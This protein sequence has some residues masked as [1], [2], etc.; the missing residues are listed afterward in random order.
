MKN[1]IEYNIDVTKSI[2]VDY[3]RI[4]GTLNELSNNLIEKTENFSIDFSLNKD[5]GYL[6]T[7]CFFKDDMNLYKITARIYDG[8]LNDYTTIIPKELMVSAITEV[9]KL[10]NNFA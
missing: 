8:L 9:N 2:E 4:P 1:V 5:D 6:T 3:K 7:Y 10:I